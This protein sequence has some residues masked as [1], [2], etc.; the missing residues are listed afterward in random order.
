MDLLSTLCNLRGSTS[1]PL[2]G[3]VT[4]S[5]FLWIS[6]L[7]LSLSLYLSF[8][9]SCPLMSQN[10]HQVSSLKPFAPFW[11]LH[12]VLQLNCFPHFTVCH[13]PLFYSTCQWPTFPGSWDSTMEERGHWFSPFLSQPL[14]HSVP[15]EW[16]HRGRERGSLW[17]WCLLPAYVA[18]SKRVCI[19]SHYGPR[20]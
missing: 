17:A 3:R 6:Y 16:P 4:V 19:R 10:H 8:L 14:A 18:G 15:A 7:F 5:F 1:C 20:K 2:W 13:L 9:C 11:L 12:F